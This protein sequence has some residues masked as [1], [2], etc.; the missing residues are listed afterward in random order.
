MTLIKKYFCLNAYFLV[1]F[2]FVL[3]LETSCTHANLALGHRNIPH[4]PHIALLSFD[5]HPGKRH[6]LGTLVN[7]HRWT[8]YNAITLCRP[9]YRL[10][11]GL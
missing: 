8:K 4:I 9:M 3:L 6:L 2:A 7:E 5:I 11:H 10:E 1:L